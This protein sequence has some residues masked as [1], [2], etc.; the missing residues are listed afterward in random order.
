MAGRLDLTVKVPSTPR[1]VLFCLVSLA[2]LDRPHLIE[3]NCS[4][5][6]GLDE[7]ADRCVLEG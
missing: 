7:P 6:L 4:P 2:V 3:V 5:A 1:R